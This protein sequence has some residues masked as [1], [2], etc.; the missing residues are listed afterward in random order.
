M[1]PVTLAKIDRHIEGVW[2]FGI[3]LF[4]VFYN[5]FFEKKYYTVRPQRNVIRIKNYNTNPTSDII[6]YKETFI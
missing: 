2:L 3:I 5:F 1:Q 6:N 4:A